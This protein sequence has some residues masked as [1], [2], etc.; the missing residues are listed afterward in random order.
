MNGIDLVPLAVGH[1]IGLG[2][3]GSGLGIGVLGAKFLEGSARQPELMD[4]LQAKVFLLAGITDGAFIIV[5]GIGLWF[6]T[7]NPFSRG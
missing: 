5:T 7:A 3:I 4:R 2:A 6:S 1:M